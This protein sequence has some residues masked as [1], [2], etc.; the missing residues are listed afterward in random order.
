MRQGLFRVPN[1]PSRAA[2]ESHLV[3]HLILASRR[4]VPML[5]A[6]SLL[7][8][9]WHPAAST[10]YSST[11]VPVNLDFSAIAASIWGL[12]LSGTATLNGDQGVA[13][14]RA[15]VNPTTLA[16]SGI[17]E[18][19]C[20]TPRLIE[21]PVAAVQA[22]ARTMVATVNQTPGYVLLPKLLPRQVR[23]APPAG[24]E[25]ATRRLEVVSKTSVSVFLR[26]LKRGD[27]GERSAARLLHGGKLWSELWS[28]RRPGWCSPVQPD[29]QPNV[30][31]AMAVSQFRHL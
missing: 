5:I 12:V 7:L 6:A 27:Q 17:V 31:L 24:F 14:L 18:P 15:K 10:A 25:P 19:L 21:E 3:G 4:F 11:T 9:R 2:R 29:H 1:S 23:G 20:D 26:H 30:V 13:C 22:E 16:L 8:A 28:I